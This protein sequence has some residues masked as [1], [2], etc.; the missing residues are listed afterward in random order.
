MSLDLLLFARGDVLSDALGGSLHGFAGHF[1][2]RQQFHLLASVIERRLLTHHG[3]HAAHSR[4][5]FRVLYIEFDI[6]W[7][8]ALVAVR[9]QIIGTRYFH[10]ADCGENGLGT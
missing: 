9:A 10:S 4:R 3:Q 1:Q 5:I 2:T 8:L 7:K 6:G